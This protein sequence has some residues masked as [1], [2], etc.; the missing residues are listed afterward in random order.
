MSK[1]HCIVIAG[2]TAVGK[3]SLAIAVAQYYNTAIISADSRQCFR[4]LNI[5]VAKPSAEQLQ[6]V[7]HY[8]IDSHSI[9]DEVTAAT[10]EQYA[11]DKIGQLFKEKDIVVVAGGT[12]LYIKAFCEGMDIIPEIQPG[13]RAS[14]ADMYEKKGIEWLQQEIREK[15]PLFY[16]TGELQ[17]PQRLMR[18]LEVLE[19]TG[20]SIRFYQQGKKVTRD[21]DIIKIGLDLPRVD[22]YRNINHRV[23]E[24]MTAGL[25][26]ELQ[27]LKNYEQLNALRTVGYKELF[28]FIH[29]SCTMEQAVELIKKNT[30][31]Y[32]KRQITWFNKDENMQWFSPID[33]RQ[34]IDFVDNLL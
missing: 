10:F 21:F 17:N 29:G 14:I 7:K 19:S 23:D 8:F 33:S 9:L 2:P 6:M 22:L 13:T 24:M 28:S 20:N 3:T 4:E 26:N 11:L 31:N 1:K 5:G 18:A 12:G 15:D 27:G 30:R 16:E 34:V 32:A 25:L